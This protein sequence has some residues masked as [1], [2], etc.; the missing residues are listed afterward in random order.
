MYCVN[1][2]NLLNEN[3]DAC[4][5]CGHP[6]KNKQNTNNQEVVRHHNVQQEEKVSA[7]IVSIIGIVGWA[8]I[9]FI[10]L[11]MTAQ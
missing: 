10:P 4:K 9:V 7:L 8:L 11:F 5:K 3:D 2:G 1:C 6:V